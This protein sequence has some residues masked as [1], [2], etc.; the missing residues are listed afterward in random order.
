MAH[1][2]MIWVL[3]RYFILHKRLDIYETTTISPAPQFNAPLYPSIPKDVP[4]TAIPT[5]PTTAQ[6][7]A[8]FQT[9]PNQ[10][11]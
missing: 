3:C 8:M 2:L 4:T 7:T 10:S 11:A 9:Y 1:L 5:F 6:T